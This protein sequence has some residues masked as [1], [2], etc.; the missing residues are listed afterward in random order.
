MSTDMISRVELVNIPEIQVR[1]ERKML[2]NFPQGLGSMM[3]EGFAAIQAAGQMPAGPPILLY[4]DEVYTPEQV[5]TECAWPVE[6][7]KLATGTL[8]AITAAHYLHTGPY[9]EMEKVYPVLMQWISEHGYRPLIPMREVYL[10]DPAI[11]PPEQ[12]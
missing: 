3:N 7:A 6:D 12:L 10:N 4:H 8:P 2:S 9:E 5:D 1:A 11:T